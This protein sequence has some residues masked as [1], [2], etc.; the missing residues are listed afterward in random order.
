MTRCCQQHVPMTSFGPPSMITMIMCGIVTAKL[1]ASII[2]NDNNVPLWA[3]PLLDTSCVLGFVGLIFVSYRRQPRQQ[4]WR[5]TCT[6]ACH[7]TDALCQLDTILNSA[8]DAVIRID[9]IGHI[10]GWNNQA[11]QIFGWNAHEALGRKVSEL[12]IPDRW[13]TAHEQAMLRCANGAHLE[14]WSGRRFDISAL[15][16]SGDEF[17]IELTICSLG[18]A[19]CNNFIA[20]IRDKSQEHLLE[21]QHILATRMLEHSGEAI[22]ITDANNVIVSVNP[23]FTDIT[24]YA[25]EEAVGR[26][27]S[28]LSSGIHDESYYESMWRGLR[29]EGKWQGEIWNRRKSGEVYPEWLSIACCQSESGPINYIAIFSDITAR[30]VAEERM[31]KLAYLDHLTG[32]PNRLL[33]KDRLEQALSGARRHQQR[34]AVLFMDLDRF[35]S[36]NDT[37]GHGVGDQLLTEV[38]DRISAT[39]REEDTVSRVGGDEFVVVL[40]QVN[41][42][43]HLE[44]VAHKL[45]SA[46]SAPYDIDGTLVRTSTS[47]GIATY[48]ETGTSANALIKAADKAM[49]QAKKAGRGQ[50]RFSRSPPPTA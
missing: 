32:L 25:A 12:I 10:T 50:Y 40:P 4:G 17:P 38:A 44:T 27:P 5:Q 45:I 15:H 9:R 43:R 37:Y 2:I 26:K 24:G 14:A 22:V 47:I 46:L 23:A 16:R 1:L 7:S 33:L 13:R 11:D 3:S 18:S 6:R 21:E 20:F 39:L 31:E 36:V 41:D 29:N 30:K 34:L 48:P 19:G 42:V 35:K 49:Y 28:M 8:V